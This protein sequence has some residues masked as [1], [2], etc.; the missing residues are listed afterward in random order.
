MST[1]FRFLLTAIPLVFMVHPSHAD[2]ARD[3]AEALGAGVVLEAGQI[4]S[5]RVAVGTFAVVI[6]GQG[7]QHPV[8]GE[9]ESLETVRGYIQAVD[10]ETLTL[11]LGRDGLPERIAV[12]RIQ[13]LLLVDWPRRVQ[14]HREAFF[15]I[16]GSGQ[17]AL[18][19]ESSI[20]VVG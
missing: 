13:T 8:S 17:Y 20:E 18:S 6:Y 12:D 10:A 7:E 15:E 1:V 3:P 11:A 14:A 5:S 19:A 2:T 9:W 4:D 16:G